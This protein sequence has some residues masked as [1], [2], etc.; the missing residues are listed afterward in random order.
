MSVSADR[1]RLLRRQAGQADVRA[2][3][4]A[5]DGDALHD[6]AAVDAKA[7]DAAP[8]GEL[9]PPAAGADT[10]GRS[11]AP[12]HAPGV[13]AERLRLL[14]RQV[15]GLTPAARKANA[16]MPTR[17]QRAAVPSAALPTARPPLRD[18]AAARHG[19]VAG[20]PNEARAAST[21]TPRALQSSIPAPPARDASVFLISPDL[22]PPVAGSAPRWVDAAV[23]LK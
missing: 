19:A 12:G 2:P 1:L 15:G 8:V 11:P 20:R 18:N 16:V 3:A 13:S 5:D 7:V 9:A 6:A 22:Q 4:K 21:R 14:R 23:T 10:Q 17:A